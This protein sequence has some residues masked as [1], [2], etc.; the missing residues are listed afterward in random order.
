MKTGTCKLCLKEKLLCKESHIIPKF[1]LKKLK[2]ERGFMIH[3]DKQLRN[4]INSVRNGC[5]EDNVL[6]QEC[7]K[8]IRKYEDFVAK[9]MFP[10]KGTLKNF[11]TFKNKNNITFLNLL[12]FE[13]KDYKLFKLF[14]LSLLWRFSI[15]SRPFFEKVKFKKETEEDLRKMVY[16]EDPGNEYDYP[17]TIIAPPL[18]KQGDQEFFDASEV[19]FI[20]SPI[21]FSQKGKYWCDFIIDGNRFRVLIGKGMKAK[22]LSISKNG[23]MIIINTVEAQNRE[24]KLRIDEINKVA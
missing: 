19:L 12:N 11:D 18:F 24:N 23:I 13:E 15:S 3:L 8:T 5:Y 14:I 1:C 17:C 9:I 2:D 20:R 21:C 10:P 7:E 6:C 22:F 4:P 16:N